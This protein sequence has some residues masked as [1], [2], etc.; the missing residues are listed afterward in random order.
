MSN[1]DK[2]TPDDYLAAGAYLDQHS[3]TPVSRK[4]YLGDGCYVEWDGY[5]LVLT[6]EDGIR[7]TNTV[8]LESEVYQ[9][10]V[11]YVERLKEKS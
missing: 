4:S 6:T 11:D 3:A 10:L 5:A 1:A 9:A 7:A 8:Y 2:P